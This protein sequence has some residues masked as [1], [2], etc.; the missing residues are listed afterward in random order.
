MVTCSIKNCK[1]R[2][3]NLSGKKVKFFSLPK[4]ENVL[5]QWFQVC[6]FKSD[7]LKDGK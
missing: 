3:S 4:N 6:E 2:T 7:N 5:L 1:N